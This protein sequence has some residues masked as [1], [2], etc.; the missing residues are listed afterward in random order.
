M[1]D[2][3]RIC[4]SENINPNDEITKL[5]GRLQATVASVETAAA[6]SSD[7]SVGSP[8]GFL[9]G[10][11]WG[12]KFAQK[13]ANAFLL[14]YDPKEV[15]DIHQKC[16]KA[17]QTEGAPNEAKKL[18]LADDA[19]QADRQKFRTELEKIKVDE[20][21]TSAFA[22]NRRKILAVIDKDGN[23][24]SQPSTSSVGE[25]DIKAPKL[26]P[27]GMNSAISG[28]K[29]VLSR[30]AGGLLGALVGFGVDYGLVTDHS[31]S[32]DMASNG[33]IHIGSASFPVD[34]NLVN[35]LNDY[36]RLGEKGP[37]EILNLAQKLFGR[38]EA[39]Q[40]EDVD[41]LTEFGQ[42]VKGIVEYGSFPAYIKSGTT[43]ETLVEQFNA[44]KRCVSSL[45]ARAETWFDD[46]HFWQTVNSSDDLADDIATKLL[47]GV[48]YSLMKKV[49]EENKNKKTQT[50][51]QERGETTSLMALY[52]QK[53]TDIPENT[54]I[55]Y[56]Q[57]ERNV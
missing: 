30:L 28:G 52:G 56:Q 39:G 6:S 3:R 45:N 46:D 17:M 4:M 32:P 42:V 2:E 51:N 53:M 11:I 40:I 8:L 13:V 35:A 1:V 33:K 25:L 20:N 22:K 31:Y 16:T 36:H 21:D 12:P 26:R 37:E 23:F 57:P 49:D 5:I 10:V 14:E 44:L 43:S 9:V 18:E 24:V 19:T 48:M 50:M 47:E 29:K 55:I 15:M 34:D 7:I 27:R 54:G 38:I 41:F